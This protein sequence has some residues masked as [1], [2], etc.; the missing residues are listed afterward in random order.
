MST[1][2]GL[3]AH[4]LLNHFVV[5]LAPLTAVLAILCALWPAAR[6]RLIWLVVLLAV[7]T[8][9]LTPVT[10]GAGAWLAARVNVAPAMA[11]VLAAHEQLG[12]MLIYI[13]AA[14]LATVALLA[15]VHVRQTRGTSVSLVAQSVI[16]VLVIVAAAA[17][18]IQT[19]RIG[20]SGARAAWGDV[21]SSAP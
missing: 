19:Y 8:V 9:A 4:I 5:V 21:S 3:P 11:P 15:A 14:L 6:R 1:F 16:G 18:L 10:A 13:V 20:D 17:T 7:A 12:S 2:N